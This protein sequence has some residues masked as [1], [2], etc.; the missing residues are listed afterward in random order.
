M[1]R[2]RRVT[3]LVQRRQLLRLRLAFVELDD[4]RIDG[5][6]QRLRITEIPVQVDLDEQ[7]GQV[8]VVLPDDRALAADFAPVRALADLPM[9]MTA[10]VVFE[11][12]DAEAPA[13]RSARAS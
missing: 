1:L 10:H 8:L 11:A 5:L 7:Q 13:T 9:A 4:L 12:L 6:R 3:A 2:R